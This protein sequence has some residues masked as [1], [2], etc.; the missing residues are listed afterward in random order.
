MP[1]EIPRNAILDEA[2]ALTEYA[3]S[4]RYPGE[5]EDV[6]PEELSTAVEIA[7][8]VLSWASEIVSA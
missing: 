7:Q 3:V 1:P 5:A 2:A 6:T 8:G 4:S